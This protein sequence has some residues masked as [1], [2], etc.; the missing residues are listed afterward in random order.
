[1]KGTKL[2]VILNIAENFLHDP[3]VLISI[4]SRNGK[5]EDYRTLLAYDVNV[6]NVLGRDGGTFVSSWI[7]NFMKYGN[8]PKSCPIM[9]VSYLNICSEV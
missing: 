7:N 1:M 5:T 6:C 9:K 8:L 2:D 3:W 4:A